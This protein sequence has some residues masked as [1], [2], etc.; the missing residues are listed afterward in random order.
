MRTLNEVLVCAACFA[1]L[2]LSLSDAQSSA[3]AHGKLILNGVCGFNPSYLRTWTGYNW[4][5]KPPYLCDNNYS[6]TW[7]NS[8]CG[9]ASFI[10]C[11]PCAQD[12]TSVYPSYTGTYGTPVNPG[13]NVWGGSPLSCTLTVAR[14]GY[15]K[16]YSAP[17]AHL[18]YCVLACNTTT[19][20][21]GGNSA[22]VACPSGKTVVKTSG[23]FGNSSDCV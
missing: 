19:Y 2:A 20:C 12:Y 9:N 21:P 16:N 7:N 11:Q 6:Y 15:F 5:E 18:N 14:A 8:I 22:P 1:L 4:G 3:P 23:F 10:Y 13:F 17:C